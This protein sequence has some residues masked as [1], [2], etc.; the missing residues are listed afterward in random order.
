[1]F[2]DSFTLINKSFGE[3]FTG[4]FGGG[5]AELILVDDKNVLESG[6]EIIARP[7]GKKLQSISLLSGGEK[8]MTAIALLFAILKNKP[9]PFCVLDEIDAALDDANIG[10]FV[11]MVKSFSS[12]TQFLIVTHNKATISAAS[13]IYGITMEQ[14]GVSKPISIRF[15]GQDGSEEVLDDIEKL[16][17]EETS[18]TS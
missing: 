9:T 13:M 7:P 4:L 2:L 10:R 15:S 12:D 1:M 17:G 6:I 5:R 11:D 18:R 16:A 8:S 14:E 3:I